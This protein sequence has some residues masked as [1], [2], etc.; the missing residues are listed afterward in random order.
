M[1]FNH[2][3]LMFHHS[4][5]SFFECCSDA[6]IENAHIMSPVAVLSSLIVCFCESKENIHIFI[7]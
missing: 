3:W 5:I 4:K 1:F 6:G 7:I 2:S